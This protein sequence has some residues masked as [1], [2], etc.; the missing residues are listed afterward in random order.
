VLAATLELLVH[1]EAKRRLRGVMDMLNIS[2]HESMTKSEA[3]KVHDWYMTSY[4][5]GKSPWTTSRLELK[6]DVVTMPSMYPAWPK[7]TAMVD[8]IMSKQGQVARRAGSSV[9]YNEVV[10]MVE[11]IGHLFGPFQNQICG[12]LKSSL[13]Q[14]KDDGTGRV[15]LSDFYHAGLNGK[16]EFAESAEYLNKLGALDVSS[17]NSPRVIIPNYVWSPSNCLG[18]SETHDV[19]CI[20]ECEPLMA[21]LERK[22]GSPTALPERIAEVVSNL[23]SSTVPAGRQ[24]PALLMSRLQAVAAAN[25]GAVPLN[26]RLFAQWMHHAYPRECPYPHHSGVTAPASVFAW[27]ASH[28]ELPLADRSAMSEQAKRTQRSDAPVLTAPWETEEEL[29]TDMHHEPLVGAIFV[30]LAVACAAGCVAVLGLTRTAA[31]AVLKL[32]GSGSA[33]ATMKSHALDV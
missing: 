15:P 18:T 26:G 31:R 19:C 2:T 25:D 30:H 20:S 1:G 24:L 29:V 16:W 14:V 6:E 32:H 9:T 33:K 22:I 3:H 21:Q 4:M 5:L 7:V 27:E 17:P 23:A 8:D 13:M 28:H 11:G 12:G 10:G